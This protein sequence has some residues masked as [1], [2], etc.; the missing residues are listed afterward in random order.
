MSFS[1]IFQFNGIN[2]MYRY[3]KSSIS[4]GITVIKSPWERK[5]GFFSIRPCIL[6]SDP[7]ISTT[8]GLLHW[9]NCG[10]QH[11]NKT[12]SF[13]HKKSSKEFWIVPSLSPHFP[14]WITPRGFNHI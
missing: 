13:L 4:K 1:V 14:G 3:K 8:M 10:S 2:H 9:G 7:G 5:K 12:M 6:N 11:T